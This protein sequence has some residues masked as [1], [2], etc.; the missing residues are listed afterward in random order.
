MINIKTTIYSLILVSLIS[1]QTIDKKPG[2][3]KLLPL[4]QEFLIEGES[5]LGFNDIQDFYSSSGAELPNVGATLLKDIQATNKKANA[6][7]VFEIDESLDVKAEGYTMEISKK[8]TDK[9]N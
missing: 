4:P 8:Q 6:D 5:S 2:D 1:C 7:I 3:F 9:P